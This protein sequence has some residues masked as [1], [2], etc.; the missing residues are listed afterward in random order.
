MEPLELNIKAKEKGPV[1]IFIPMGTK[2]YHKSYGPERPYM[3]C[4]PNQQQLTLISLTSGNIFT[5]QYVE[6]QHNKEYQKGTT[7]NLFEEQFGKQWTKIGD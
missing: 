3:L 5:F 6:I 1:D 2:F 7:Q 4:R